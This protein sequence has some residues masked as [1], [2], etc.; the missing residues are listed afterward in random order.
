MDNN[1]YSLADIGM[2]TGGGGFGGN[3]ALWVILL[4]A[5]FMNGGGWGNRGYSYE[6]IATAADVQR[7]TD[8]AALERQNNEII[9]SVRQGVYD[10]MAATREGNYN[11]LG[12]LRD[13]QGAVNNSFTAMQNCCCEIKQQILENRYLDERNANQVAQAV[14]A[15]GEATRALLNAQENQRL[16]DELAVSR[17]ANADYAQSQYI[18]GQIGRWYSNPPCYGNACGCGNGYAN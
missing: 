14:H 8:F 15:E 17:S 6:G 13:I 12:E 18:L 1:G 3:N 10:N 7:A 9:S 5:F 11:L 16:R 2:A 4:L